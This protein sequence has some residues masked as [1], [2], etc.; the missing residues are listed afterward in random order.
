MISAYSDPGATGNGLSRRYDRQLWLERSAV[1]TARCLLAPAALDRLAAR[2]SE[3]S[4]TAALNPVSLERAGF[5]LL[6]TLD[7]AQP[8]ATCRRSGQST[9]R[10]RNDGSAQVVSRPRDRSRTETVR[11]TGRVPPREQRRRH[12]VPSWCRSTLRGGRAHE[13]RARSPGI[14]GGVVGQQAAR[15]PCSIASTAAWMASGASSASMLA[16]T[17]RPEPASASSKTRPRVS[18]LLAV[19]R[20]RWPG[21]PCPRGGRCRQAGIHGNGS[22]GHGFLLSD[23]DRISRE[24]ATQGPGQ[25]RQRALGFGTQEEQQGPQ[26]ARRGFRAGQGE[27]IRYAKATHRPT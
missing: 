23:W 17:H 20:G 16:P 25:A 15:R 12:R 2:R 18:P 24:N 5:R 1:A 26:T 7:P 19:R 10:K 13:R 14:S 8:T 27:T 21:G 4:R 3:R 6:W 11:F 22:L 9:E